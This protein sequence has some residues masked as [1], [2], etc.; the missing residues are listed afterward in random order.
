MRRWLLLLAFQTI[1]FQIPAQNITLSEIPALNQLPVGEIFCVYQDSEGYMW[2]GTTKGGLYRDDGYSLKAFR[3]DSNTPDLIA[4]NYV[5][6]ITE[7]RNRQIWFGTKRGAYILDKT[8]YRIRPL[9]DEEIKKWGITTVDVTSDGTIWVSSGSSIF[10][11]NSKEEKLATYKTDWKGTP[12]DIREFYQDSDHIIWIT[13]SKGGLLRYDKS[14]D[15]FVPCPWPFEESPYCVLKDACT[16]YY[17]IGTWGKGI[18]RFDPNEM[19]FEK[20]FVPQSAAMNGGRFVSSIA[21]DSVMHHLWVTTTDDLYAYEV[22]NSNTLQLVPTAGFI[23]PEKKILHRITND[24]LGNMWVA[25]YY[26]RPFILSFQPDNITSYTL[27]DVK[28]RLETPIAPYALIY[29]NGNYWF[30]QMRMN[31]YFYKPSSNNLL[32]C[33][34]EGM[35]SFFEKSDSKGGVYTIKHDSIVMHI[36]NDG[37]RTTETEFCRLPIRQHERIR[38]LYED[39]SGNLWIGTTYDLIRYDP[40]LKEFHKEWENTGIVNRIASSGDGS[41]YVA[42]ESDGFLRLSSDGSKY[43][44]DPQNGD[45]FLKM[46]IVSGQNAW[47][48][49]QQNSIYY[50]DSQNNSFT[51]K[52]FEYDLDGDIIYDAVSDNSGNLWI[53][54]DK[55]IVICN[56]EKQTFRLIRCSDPSVP[57]DNFSAIYKDEEGSMHIGGTGGIIKIIPDDD[58]DSSKNALSIL[59]TDIKV[60]GVSRVPVHNNEPIILQSNERNLELFFS[61]FDF[62]NKDKIRFAF[63]IKGQNSQWNYLPE[64][65]NNIYLA[66]LSK[67]NYELEVK[68]TNKDGVWKEGCIPVIIQRLPAYYETWWA[69][70]LYALIFAMMILFI[71]W[72]YIKHQKKKQQIQADEEIAWMKYQFFTN[73]SHELRTPLTLI[74]TPLETI[75]KKISDTDLKQQLGLINRNAQNLLSLVNQL[76]DFRKVEMGGERLYLTK[77]DINEFLSGIYENFK[78]IANQKELQLKYNSEISSLYLFFDHDKLRKI[79]NNLLSNAIKFTDANG[80]ITMSLY[81]ER[82]DEKECI[83]IRVEDSGRG[84]PVSELPYIFD[85]FHQVDTE[86]LNTGSGIGLHLVKEYT[87]MHGG[88]IYVRSEPGKGSLFFVYIPTDLMQDAEP[89]DPIVG[90]KTSIAQSDGRKKVLIVEDNDEFR[91]YMKRELSHSYIVFEAANGT[92]GERQ[93]FELELDIIITDLMM[94]EMDGIELCH[95]IKNNINIS[96]IPVI[97]L[98]ANG[99]I[100]NE[101]RGYREGADAYITKPFHWEILLSRIQNLLDQK[102]Q[103]QQIFKKEIDVN[104]VDITISSL[105]ERFMNKVL[106]V[107][108]KN[109]SNTEYS[110]EDLSRDAAVSRVSLYRKI[111]SIT[112]SSPTDFVKSIRLKKAAEL[113]KQ[114]ELSVTDIAYSVG[115]SSPSYFT[116]SF[117]K[118]FGIL[119][120]KYK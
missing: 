2:Y 70:S 110:I 39:T 56:I 11:Y 94:P 85:R 77:G 52:N 107:I 50:Y 58:A 13:Q 29:E 19:N 20:M 24:R 111:N 114:G 117:K 95:R 22:T 88:E 104:P 82:R 7:D 43:Q 26:P 18:V 8:N 53:L 69:Y 45:N 41:I 30:W 83:V 49:S 46:S 34:T 76:L 100:E 28:E 59:L 17:W 47:V 38:T 36:Q 54:S 73:V 35:I 67:G 60:N 109:M 99:N 66:E 105:D 96:H 65:Q 91:E 16:Q 57:L 116:Q 4:S 40:K 81:K 93:A 86:N 80:C 102:Q 92:D 42:T 115:F 75:I 6:C 48:V 74:I 1:L 5:T 89:N 87:T 3:S 79:V 72:K 37:N 12:Q 112:G 10:R 15:R 9:A 120:N 106:E 108:E 14:K 44:Y 62:L 101:K 27:S 71:V 64:G 68:I 78:L 55:K 97:L 21:Q 119:P 32:L 25:S 84:I 33:N 63:R 23:S 61:S 31:L 90:N 51:Q 103:R 118:M 113:L 98:T